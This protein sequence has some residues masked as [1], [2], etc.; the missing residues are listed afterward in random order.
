MAD[1]WPGPYLQV[2]PYKSDVGLAPSLIAGRLLGRQTP[3][4]PVYFA[5]QIPMAVADG[6]AIR[7][8]MQAPDITLAGNAAVGVTL[9]D[10]ESH[11]LAFIVGDNG[12]IFPLESLY[13]G[14][15]RGIDPGEFGF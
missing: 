10:E 15:I 4:G 6:D 11:G 5:F 12:E 14:R 7:L 9:A 1:P 13:N 3:S 8:I 2:P